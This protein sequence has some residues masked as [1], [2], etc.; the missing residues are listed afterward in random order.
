MSYISLLHCTID[1]K[2][3]LS[4]GKRSKRVAP[5]GPANDWVENPQSLDRC[6]SR[7]RAVAHL[8]LVSSLLGS[9][10]FPVICLY[11]LEATRRSFQTND[12]ITLLLGIPSLFGVLCSC[13]K[14]RTGNKF[15]AISPVSLLCL[16]GVLLFHAYNF[17]AYMIVAV[18]E[19]GLTPSLKTKALILGYGTILCLIVVALCDWTQAINIERASYL[20]L[21]ALSVRSQIDSSEKRKVEEIP[22][23]LNVAGSFLLSFGVLFLLRAG[24]ELIRMAGY[25]YS[26][27]KGGPLSGDSDQHDFPIVEFGTTIADM[28]LSGVW[29]CGGGYWLLWKRHV[30]GY[31]CSLSLMLSTTMLF[32]GLL[33]L[34]LV[35]PHLVELPK[36]SEPS[37]NDVL[38][39]AIM[40]LVFSVPFLVM[41]QRV[42]KI[43]MVK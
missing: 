34:M 22:T 18:F 27:E 7:T 3:I 20:L 36:S 32:L 11:R 1:D 14:L 28:I 31:I 12:V 10:V 41:L 24:K 17:I 5:I 19:H 40:G 38:F 13:Q 2:K 4:G 43:Q 29:I 21:N 15:S 35:Q 23:I 26:A 6:L 30:Y 33:L 9:G 8:I 42:L 39:V 25:L 37:M 16:P